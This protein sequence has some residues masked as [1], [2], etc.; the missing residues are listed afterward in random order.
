MLTLD[1]LKREGKDKLGEL[2]GSG[3]IPA[4]FYGPKEESTPITV[5][6]K[7]FSKIWKEAGESTVVTLVGIGDEKEALIHD[8]DIDPVLYSPRHV[9]FYVME[10]GKKVQVA[11]PLEFVGVSQA[12]KGLGGVLSKILHEVEVEAMPK[13]L[14]QSLEVDISKLE[15][16][17]DTVFAGDIILL[18]GVELITDKD[19]PVASVSEAKEEEVF[20]EQPEADLDSI[21]VEPKG[22]QEDGETDSPK[23]EPKE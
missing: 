3:N 22:K 17:S 9:D 1:I 19:E 18:E 20:D 23:E 11:I 14:P 8:V 2:R 4:V 13:L 15:D 10:K 21:E 16:F 7:E 12:I 5:S 6:K